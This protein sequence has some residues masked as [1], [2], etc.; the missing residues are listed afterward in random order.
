MPGP[1]VEKD[2]WYSSKKLQWRLSTV[3]RIAS[4]GM[5]IAQTVIGALAWRTT[6]FYFVA[7]SFSLVISM[8]NLLGALSKS[9]CGGSQRKGGHGRGRASGAQSRTSSPARG[10]GIQIRVLRSGSGDIALNDGSWDTVDL[11]L[12]SVGGSSVTSLVSNIA[13]LV[14]T[15]LLLVSV[16]IVSGT[17]YNTGA[18]LAVWNLTIFTMACH[19]VCLGSITHRF[20]FFVGCSN[21][22]VEDDGEYDDDAELYREPVTE[23][24]RDEPTQEASARA[25]MTV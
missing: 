17:W 24:Y 25:T 16:A 22:A 19:L 14:A 4:V 6:D 13:D 20:R 9:V 11:R 15:I 2:Q 7:T 8:A 12:P 1:R 18:L 5:T 3:L 23:Q 21:G 10:F